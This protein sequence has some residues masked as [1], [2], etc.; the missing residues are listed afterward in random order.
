MAYISAETL[1]A[2]ALT[3]IVILPAERAAWSAGGLAA[4]LGMLLAY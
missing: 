2:F 4:M 1:A 3:S